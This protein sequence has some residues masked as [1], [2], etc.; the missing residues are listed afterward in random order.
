MSSA[1]NM[2]SDQ[3]RELYQRE[4][5]SFIPDKVFDAHA[6]VW[7]EQDA[8][9]RIPHYEGDVGFERYIR[10]MQDLHPG[11]K[12]GALFIGCANPAKPQSLD[13]GNQWVADQL[14]GRQ[15]FRGEFF[16][17]PDD[18]PD[19]VRQEVVRLRLHGLKCYHTLA[20]HRPTWESEI[21]DYLPECLVSV[22]HDLRLAITLHLVKSRACADPSNIHWIQQYCRMYPNMKLILA[23]SARGFQ[24]AHNLEGLPQLR[25]LRNLYFD[26][27]A[28]CEPAAHQTIVRIMGHRRLMYGSDLPV[29]HL[30]GRSL[31]A[32]DT[33]LWLY[34][35]T[36]VWEGKHQQVRPA[37]IGL[38]H[39]RSLKWACWSERLSDRQVEDIF[40]NNAAEVFELD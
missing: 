4:L 8:H 25:E 18:D 5:A 17:R 24:P 16:V 3:D 14:N 28:N 35:D 11:R 27:S 29:S 23:H 20:Q 37:L 31:A 1:K 26:T 32:V 22:A 19:W 33:F 13:R 36:P 38:E 10:L 2:A 12:T 15:N 34:E 7:R 30:R 39:L 6:H 21:P 9:F 40:W